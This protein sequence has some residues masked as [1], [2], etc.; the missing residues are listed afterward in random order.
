MGGRLR[1]IFILFGGIVL[2]HVTLRLYAK[3]HKARLKPRGEIHR[4][5]LLGRL[6]STYLL[7]CL[8]AFIERALNLWPVHGS[9]T[10]LGAGLYATAGFLQW[11]A[12]R[13]LG[14]AYSP[15]IEVRPGQRLIQHGLYAWVRHPLLSSLILELLGVTL[16]FNA[17]GSAALTLAAFIPVVRQRMHEEEKILRSHFGD[18][19]QRYALEVGAL[20]PR[21]TC[22]ACVNAPQ[23]P[24]KRK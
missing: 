19:Y 18:S 15:E 6:V 7:I 24:S 16:F 4:P 10:L 11:R 14:D 5:E 12:F 13:D 8:A 1:A 2:S 21:R 17:Y 22:G 9:V 20:I 3:A 23:V